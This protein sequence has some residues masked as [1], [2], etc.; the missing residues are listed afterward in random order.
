MKTS[1]KYI[2]LL[3]LCITLI[4]CSKEEITETNYPGDNTISFNICIDDEKIVNTKS[5]NPRLN[6]INNLH[7]LV[8]DQNGSFLSRTQA[9][10]GSNPET[11]TIQLT[12]T[13]P[14]LPQEKRKRIIHFICN[15]DWSDFSDVKNQGKHESE[16]VAPLSTTKGNVAYW[17]RTE[18]ENGI[19]ESDF[20]NE[21]TLLRNVSKISV[22]NNSDQSIENQ[23][24]TDISFG[25]YNYADYGT[26][27]PF[28][29]TSF[30]FDET[31]V[32]ES[33]FASLQTIDE[34]NFMKAGLVNKPGES[35]ICYE[36]KNSTA[37][38]PLHVIIKGKYDTDLTYTYYKIDIIPE[39]QEELYDIQ[40]NC[41]YILNITEVSGEGAETLQEA[42]NGPASNNILYSVVLEKYTSISDGTS[43]LNI[44]TTE[45]T[46]VQASKEFS[47]SY[48]YIPDLVAGTEDNSYVTFSLEQDSAKPVVDVSSVQIDRTSKKATYSARTVNNVPEYDIHNARLILTAV[49]NG[50]T[51]RR[52]VK[53]RFRK[54]FSLSNVSVVPQQIPTVIDQPVEI[55]FS[56]PE[57]IPESM[58]PLKVFIRTK[59]LSP[60][61]NPSFDDKLTLDYGAPGVYRYCYIATQPGNY[62]THF[63]TTSTVTNEILIVESDLFSPV[64]VNL[65]N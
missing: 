22:I 62:T 11:Y 28:N 4:N 56:I 52:V 64:S 15:Y 1:F 60:N 26:V 46:F 31:S 17:Q 19:S 33:P 10:P 43:A 55:S 47:I 49:N 54:P 7:M 13:D 63:L 45:K 5:S 29:K 14:E 8:F 34:N 9:T 50:I 59:T 27:A 16:L 48:S 36:R 18:L 12:H 57:N 30:T 41:H 39:G 61:L 21:I 6:T 23:A 58:F 40:R 44:E 35:F 2:S 65:T 24:L 53:L 20:P 3:L 37:S 38:T 51:L 42:I 25:I 32:V